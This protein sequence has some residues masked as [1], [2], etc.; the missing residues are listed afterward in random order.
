MELIF[1]H[2]FTL[3]VPVLLSLTEHALESD[4]PRLVRRL[5]D[6]LVAQSGWPSFIP[7]VSRLLSL[8]SSRE[9]LAHVDTG[10]SIAEDVVRMR[11]LTALQS[12]VTGMMQHAA[13]FR[14]LAPRVW[15][16]FEDL[17]KFGMPYQAKSYSA[18]VRAL[19]CVRQLEV[20]R[21]HELLQSIYTKK[22]TATVAESQTPASPPC[23]SW[24]DSTGAPSQE[25]TAS[26]STHSSAALADIDTPIYGVLS[27]LNEIREYRLTVEAYDWIVANVA[28]GGSVAIPL[29]PSPSQVDQTA[30]STSVNG[31]TAF[32]SGDVSTGGVPLCAFNTVL[33]ALCRKNN[34]YKALGLMKARL[35]DT[36]QASSYNYVLRGFLSDRNDSRA[37]AVMAE[38]NALGFVLDDL[39]YCSIINF[40]GKGGRLD[41]AMALL[42][43]MRLE[44][45]PVAP[46]VLR[47]FFT[48]CA[49]EARMDLAEEMWDEFVPSGIM[50]RH[51]RRDQL[52][53]VSYA[54]VKAFN[55]ACDSAGTPEKK[56][57]TSVPISIFPDQRLHQPARRQKQG[58][59]NSREGRQASVVRSQSS[60]TSQSIVG[61]EQ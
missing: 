38:M 21:L 18:A 27:T 34:S 2:Q 14:P 57:L 39:S 29:L 54:L 23:R 30:E 41:E 17:P 42:H 32:S 52:H 11:R 7:F 45:I 13:R 59:N 26:G 4:Q 9:A 47:T 28:Q 3:D 60:N 51:L 16:L 61:G 46:L 50:S 8:M 48:V 49:D 6:I 1:I 44:Q 43:K 33:E 15:Q 36:P 24:R 56:K 58:R 31:N 25:T 12:A 53:S 22:S 55:H 35:S 37:N 5:Y 20:P 19:F 10:L 40:W